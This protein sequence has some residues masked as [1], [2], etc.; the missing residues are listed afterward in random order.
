[1]GTLAYSF[2]FLCFYFAVLDLQRLTNPA[3]G[4][5]RL[6]CENSRENRVKQSRLLSLIC[7]YFLVVFGFAV[8]SSGLLKSLVPGERRHYQ[9]IKYFQIQANPVYYEVV[10]NGTT[11]AV[12]CG[13]K[14][15][16]SILNYLLFPSKV[17]WKFTVM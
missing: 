17:T 14:H 8:G 16:S 1:M 15:F 11:K 9:I 2:P 5:P 4:V 13:T 6:V 7:F 3:T 12:P 10:R